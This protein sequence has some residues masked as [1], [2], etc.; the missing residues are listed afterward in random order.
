M[1]SPWICPVCGRPEPTTPTRAE[2]NRVAFCCIVATAYALGIGAGAI[3]GPGT[4]QWTLGQCLIL[5][6]GAIGLILLGWGAAS[7][8]IA[9]RKPS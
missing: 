9:R 2:R 1:Q 4:W 6:M 3:Y 5:G 7:A 8:I